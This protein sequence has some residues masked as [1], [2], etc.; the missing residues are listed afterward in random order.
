[1]FAYIKEA[2]NNFKL[3][4]RKLTKPKVLVLLGFEN[5]FKVDFDASMVQNRGC[6]KFKKWYIT[7]CRSM[8]F[9]EFKKIWKLSKTSKIFEI[10]RIFF[11]F[12]SSHYKSN[13][14]RILRVGS[15]LRVILLNFD[16]KI[17]SIIWRVFN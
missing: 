13:I 14:I 3:F 5:F 17:G 15:N 9:S 8:N 2:Y 4:K 1:M 7:A 16:G 12:I 11:F 10:V 6:E